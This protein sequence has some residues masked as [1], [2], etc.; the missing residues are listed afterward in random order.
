MIHDRSADRAPNAGVVSN[1]GV[2]PGKVFFLD[3]H[4]K[5]IIKKSLHRR[6][7]RI[8]EMGDV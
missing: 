1:V 8:I 4:M 3:K 6:K 7:V 2:K 5:H